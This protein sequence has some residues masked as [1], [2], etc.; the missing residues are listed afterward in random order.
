[1]VCFYHCQTPTQ[2]GLNIKKTTFYF[3]SDKRNE[4]VKD[5]LRAEGFISIRDQ[6]KQEREKIMYRERENWLLHNLQRKEETGFK[7]KKKRAAKFKIE[8]IV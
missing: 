5:K 8:C 3:S 7:K 2:S 6:P 4:R 1:M